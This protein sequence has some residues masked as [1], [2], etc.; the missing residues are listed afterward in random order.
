MGVHSGFHVTF[1]QALHDSAG[2]L[3]PG[4]MGILFIVGGIVAWRLSKPSFRGM[5]GGTTTAVGLVMILLS[6]WVPWSVHGT[7][8]S[9]E[10]GVLSVNS[11]FGNVTW[12]IDGIEATYVTNDS[13]Y[14]PVLR[15]GG[16]SG[17][18]LH[19]GHFRLANGDN[20]LMFEY[21]SHPV[22]LLKYVGPATQSSGAGQSGG[23]GPGNSTSQA[24]QP[25]VLLSSPNIGV[26]K[27]AID[28]ARSDRPFPPRTGPKLGFSSGVSP[29][30]LIAAIVV[31]IAG[32]AVQ[33]D[34]RRRYYNR[35]PD[36][37]ASHWNFQGDVDG[38][39][40]KRIVM[41]LGPV[42][43]VVFGALSVVIALVPSSIL[44]QVPFWLLQFLF[45]V[46]IRWMYRRNL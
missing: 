2:A 33:L 6:L 7:G 24:S 31:A 15:T 11:G 34:L 22:L 32:F 43:A 27:S 3:V 8:W 4:V 10:N 40:S 26:L 30:G 21:G 28:A 19:A 39:M 29:V 16:Y 12:P 46:I 13:G 14:Q 37:M 1:V 20:V 36:R 5:L 18:Q 38:W 45:I 25:E 42:M 35:L 17:S 41:W 9:L 23:T 44:L